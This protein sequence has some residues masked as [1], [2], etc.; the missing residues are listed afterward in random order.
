MTF[1]RECEIVPGPREIHLLPSINPAGRGGG[2][3]DADGGEVD[4]HYL[5]SIRK[6]AMSYVGRAF[7]PDRGRMPLPQK[8]GFWMGTI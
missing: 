6:V 2:F 8:W 5:V 4:L 1:C 7:S 3:N